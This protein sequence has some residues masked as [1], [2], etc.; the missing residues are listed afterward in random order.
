LH[1]DYRPECEPV[2]RAISVLSY[3]HMSIPCTTP[4]RPG[5]EFNQEALC[6]YLK[7]NVPKFGS[8]IVSLLQFEGVVITTHIT[9]A[10]GQSN[11][12]FYIKDDKGTEFVMRKKP[13]GK[14]LPSA[15]RNFATDFDPT[16]RC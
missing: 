9:F 6:T 5:H 7:A 15:V 14:L 8:T 12:T 4:V 16:A 10:G 13:P 1:L 2:A 3:L 11:P